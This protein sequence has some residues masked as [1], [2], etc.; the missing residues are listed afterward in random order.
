LE[1]DLD[2]SSFIYESFLIRF[3]FSLFEL[4]D[5]RCKF[6]SMSFINSFADDIDD[7]VLILEP[8]Y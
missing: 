5:N 3:F 8:V 4:S 7:S 6:P 2:R 1:A